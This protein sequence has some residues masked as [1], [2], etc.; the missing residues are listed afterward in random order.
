MKPEEH[1]QPSA[2]QIWANQVQYKLEQLEHKTAAMQQQIDQLTKRLEAAESRPQYTIENIEYRF[3]QLKVEQLDGT[4]N[5]GMTAPGTGNSDSLL[6]IEQM[7]LPQKGQFAQMPKQPSQ[8]S[9]PNNNPYGQVWNNVKKYLGN[10]GM[11]FLQALENNHRLSLDSKHKEMIIQDIEKQLPARIH[12]YLHEVPNRQEQMP[13]Q[14]FIEQ[15]TQ[16]TVTD[17]NQALRNYVDSLLYKDV[18]EETSK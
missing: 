10:E 9:A 6:P 12:Y 3:D 17:C 16:K 18:K 1:L 13:E 15:I 11:Q 2:W 8:H 7:L 14:N 5:I 4:L